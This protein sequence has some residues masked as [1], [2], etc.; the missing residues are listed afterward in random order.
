MDALS[1]HSYLE[2]VDITTKTLFC[3]LVAKRCMK[4]AKCCKKLSIFKTHSVSVDD[5]FMT[6]LSTGS[7]VPL[8]TFA[9]VFKSND[10]YT[11][12]ITEE[13]WEKFVQANP[14]VQVE[15]KFEYNCPVT[16][17]QSHMA[18]SIPLTI[19]NLN[20]DTHCHEELSKAIDLYFERLEHIMMTTGPST[21]LNEALIKA[22]K[23]CINLK[24]VEVRCKVSDETKDYYAKHRPEVQLIIDSTERNPVVGPE[25][26]LLPPNAQP[27]A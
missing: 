7:K 2:E 8:K 17:I 16:I 13:V 11:T 24:S 6:E 27:V 19:L 22:A 23:N 9:L 26:N 10:K 15:L 25:T 1:E 5:A 12:P 3:P 21:E 4:F 14:N 18:Q 20:V